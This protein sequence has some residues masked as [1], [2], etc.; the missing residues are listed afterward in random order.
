MALVIHQMNLRSWETLVPS[1]IKPGLLRNAGMT[2]QI[3]INVTDIKR[4]MILV[5]MKWMISSYRKI[6]K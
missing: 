1:I 6:I 5:I 3:E 2:P 4:T